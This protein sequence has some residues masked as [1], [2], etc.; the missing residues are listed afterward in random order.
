[1]SQTEVLKKKGLDPYRVQ[2]LG[3]ALPYGGMK[4]IEKS[5]GKGFHEIRET[6]NHVQPDG[7]D[8]EIIRA[9]IDIYNARTLGPHITLEDL[10]PGD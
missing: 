9:A 10:E 4:S 8:L 5:T 2:K 1:M 7:Y 3:K 6:F